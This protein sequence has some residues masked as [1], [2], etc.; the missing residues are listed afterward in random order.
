MISID[1]QGISCLVTGAASGLGRAMAL[2]LLRSGAHV[3]A[4]DVSEQGLS[5]LRADA[6]AD[7]ARLLGMIADIRR[8]DDCARVVDAA[9]S[10]FG[11]VGVLVNCAGLGMPHVRHDYLRQPVR[12][13]EIDEQKWRDLV[14]VNLTGTFLLSRALA[15]QMIARGW[16]RIVNVTTSFSTMIRGGNMPYGATKAALEAA[17]HAFAQDLSGTGVTLNVLIP[18]GAAATAMIPDDSPYDRAKLVDP[19]VMVAPICWLA[20]PLSDGVTGRRFVARQWDETRSLNEAAAAASAPIAWPDLAN[21]AL[22][23][24]PRSAGALKT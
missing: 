8:A 19:A 7:A 2:G 23:G 18:G 10:R 9:I 1:L 22:K 11:H 16:G 15:P 21:E 6:G 24:Q 13:W 14:D 20:S 5:A 3:T 4:L 17:S 12:F